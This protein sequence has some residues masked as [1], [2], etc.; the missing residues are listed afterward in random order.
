MTKVK[1]RREPL[2][3]QVEAAEWVTPRRKY[4]GL[5]CCDCGL[6]HK[7]EFRLVDS[8]HGPGKKI[9]LRAWRD[10]AA[11]RFLRKRQVKQ[12]ASK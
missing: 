8:W 9:Q 4:Y 2:Y 10:E 7:L 6:V 5:G 3:P 11:T 12:K 1:K